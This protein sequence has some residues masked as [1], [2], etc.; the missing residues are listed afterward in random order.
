MVQKIKNY[1]LYLLLDARTSEIKYVGKTQYPASRYYNH[2]LSTENPHCK[3]SIWVG[4]L[5]G[6]APCMVI[7]DVFHNKRLA[8]EAEYFAIDYL[9]KKGYELVN[10]H[11][12]NMSFLTSKKLIERL[13]I[14]ASYCDIIELLQGSPSSNKEII[15]ASWLNSELIRKTKL[16]KIQAYV[17]LETKKALER[18]SLEEDRSE[19][20]IASKILNG[21]FSKN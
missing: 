7:I 17:S 2:K 11:S 4:S 15:I 12:F 16:Y 5:N 10:T 3:K 13:N 1:F 21:C 18:I 8:E 20:Y 14:T 6:N 19:N 9:S